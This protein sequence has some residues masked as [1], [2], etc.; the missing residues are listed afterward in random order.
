MPALA[1]IISFFEKE[2]QKCRKAVRLDTSLL[3]QILS[4]VALDVPHP[5]G[6][7]LPRDLDEISATL[8][9]E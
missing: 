3:Q 5:N 8:M 6:F 2:I 1:L 9:R 4:V 7:R